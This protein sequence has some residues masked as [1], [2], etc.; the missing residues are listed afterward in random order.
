MYA[1]SDERSAIMEV[2]RFLYLIANTTYPTIPH[3][4]VDGIWGAETESAVIEFQRMSGNKVSGEVDYYTFEALYMAFSDAEAEI[5]ERDYLITSDGFPLRKNM[6]ND[7]VL[8]LHLLIL[9][10]QKNYD[11]LTEVTRSTYYSETTEN[12][13]IE[14]QEIFGFEKNGE[15]DAKM[16][17]RLVLELDSIILANSVYS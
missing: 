11:Y 9:E 3:V 8:L 14:L 2:Q 15:V 10:I 13:V 5:Y 17:E 16:F 4:S 1:L 6:M 7:D 12:A